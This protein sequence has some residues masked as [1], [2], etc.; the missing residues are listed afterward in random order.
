MHDYDML[1]FIS[2]D[3]GRGNGMNLKDSHITNY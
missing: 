3:N 2:F 1:C